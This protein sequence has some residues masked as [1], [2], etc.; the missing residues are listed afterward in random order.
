MK[1]YIY[2]RIDGQLTCAGK[3]GMGIFKLHINVYRPKT[4]MVIATDLFVFIVFLS[5]KPNLTE[6]FVSHLSSSI[7]MQT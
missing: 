1:I 6:T 7:C 4:S 2:P 3:L 5:L